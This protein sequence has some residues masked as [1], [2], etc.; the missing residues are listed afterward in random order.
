MSAPF[1]SSRVT[2]TVGGVAYSGWKT[3]SIARDL[4]DI[5]GKFSLANFDAGRAAAAFPGSVRGAVPSPVLRRQACTLAIDGETVLDGWIDQISG[6]TG[7]KELGT[8]FAGRDRTGDLADCAGVPNGPAEWHGATILQIAQQL[9]APFGIRVAAQAP[10]GAP[11]R[12]LAVAAH[13]SVLATI[14][15][16][17]RQR[18]LLVLSDGVGGLLLTDGGRTAA[19]ADLRCPGNARRTRFRFDDTKRFSDIYVKGQSEKAAGTRGPGGPPIGHDY[20]PGPIATPP[21]AQAAESAGILMTGHAV[22]PDVTR[23]RPTVRMV[24]T[25]SGG[26]SVQQQAEWAVRVARG[27]STELTYT[28]LDWRAGAA[29][30]LW[31]PNTVVRVTDPFAGIDDRMLIRAVKYRVGPDGE[32]PDTPVTEIDVV[33]LTA[34]DQAPKAASKVPLKPAGGGAA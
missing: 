5:S 29:N 30:A 31:R 3:V 23:Y 2:L 18:G 20:A 8:S 21:N 25:Q 26:A 28:V 17:A 6:D 1:A 32:H 13:E 16:A 11:F 33:G 14:E 34:F 4:R 22:D 15:K 27:E 19:P 24:R 10:V 9:C 7:A 12:R